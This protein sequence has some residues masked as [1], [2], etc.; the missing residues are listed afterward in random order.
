MIGAFLALLR[1]DLAVALRVRANW[2]MPVAFFT[3]VVSLF[4]LGVDTAPAVLRTLAPGVIWVAALLAGLSALERAFKEDFDNGSLEQWLITPHGVY[5]FALA[6]IVAHWCATGLP[7]TLLA[8]IYGY[9]LGMPASAL[10]VVA[11]SLAL[12]TPVLSALGAVGAALTGCL[13]R[14][15]TLMAL[16]VL[17]FYVPLLVFGAN[18]MD[19][20][21]AGLPAAAALAILGALLIMSLLLA[22]LAVAAALRVMLE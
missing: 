3:V 13:R 20:A 19:L 8:P 15:E 5:P 10:W 12:G 6:R 1:R 18:A 17:P 22:P 21:A 11:A 16:L 4:P 7:F 14:G 9:L 2:L